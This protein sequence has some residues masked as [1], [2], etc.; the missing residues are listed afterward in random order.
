MILIIL[1]E[2][3]MVLSMMNAVIQSNSQDTETRRQHSTSVDGTAIETRD[4]QQT[5]TAQPIGN[6]KGTVAANVTHP[7]CHLGV[8][9]NIR[10]F[11]KMLDDADAVQD[12]V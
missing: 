8:D 5:Y 3:A 1:K 12:S 4:L 2:Q 6:Q 9:A 7:M 11:Q 10:E